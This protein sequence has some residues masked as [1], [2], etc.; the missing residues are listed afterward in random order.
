VDQDGSS[1]DRVFRVD[2]HGNVFADGTYYGA[3]GVDTSCGT[4]CADLAETMDADQA[5]SSYEPGDVLVVNRQGLVSL[6]DTPF[7]TNVVGVYSTKPAFLAHAGDTEDQ[8][9]VALV[10]NVPVKASAENGPIV[11][12]DLLTTSSTPGH[13]MKADHFVGGA[14][15]GKA[16]EPL[17][18][19]TGLIQML[20]MLQ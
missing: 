13:A 10:G 11:P 12:G 5:A 7:A 18:E 2:W 15:I 17:D 9:P 14:I 16:M 3:G 6:S 1:L 4:D 19:G 20:V 8:V